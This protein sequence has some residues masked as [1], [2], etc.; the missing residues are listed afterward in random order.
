ML[1]T[2]AFVALA[3]FAGVFSSRAYD[4]TNVS[5]FDKLV[6]GVTGYYNAEYDK[7]M[8]AAMVETDAAKRAELLHQAE[9]LL[10]TDMP[11]IPVIHF[12]TTYLES[13]ELDDVEI[14]YFGAPLFKNTSY[15]DYVPVVE[16]EVEEP[17]DTEAA[18]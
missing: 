10:L 17:A 6:Y 11:I 9:A 8:S 15:D 1:S 14:S 4:F 7:L 2:D 13:K 16:E 5:D 18:E 12:A 3:P